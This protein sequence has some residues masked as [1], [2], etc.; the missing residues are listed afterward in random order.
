MVPS[1]GGEGGKGGE[2]GEGGEGGK[3][4]AGGAGGEDGED[5]DDGISNMEECV[6][7][8]PECDGTF[9]MKCYTFHKECRGSWQEAQAKCHEHGGK[10]LEIASQAEQDY[11]LG[12]FLL[13]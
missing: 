13:I 11:I 3:G 9:G 1:S 6:E 12:R 10:L 7:P 8:G 5:E 2:G 4:G